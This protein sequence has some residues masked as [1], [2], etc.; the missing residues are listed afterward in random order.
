MNLKDIPKENPLE[1]EIELKE[2]KMSRNMPSFKEESIEEIVLEP[3]Q[4]VDKSSELY[5]NSISF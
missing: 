4:V 2:A 1:K 5:E 3:S